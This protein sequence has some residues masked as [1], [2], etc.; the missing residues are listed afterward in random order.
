M[1][2]S[3]DTVRP[4]PRCGSAW[5]VRALPV[6]AGGTQHGAIHSWAAES[7]GCFSNPQWSMSAREVAAY[8]ERRRR[9]GWDRW[10]PRTG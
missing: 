2:V 4:C 10:L 6:V 8:R 3:L 1:A 9:L 5:K 7:A